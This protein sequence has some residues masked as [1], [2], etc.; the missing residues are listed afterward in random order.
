MPFI[1]PKFVRVL[2]SQIWRAGLLASSPVATNEHFLA[3]AKLII[4]LSCS[5]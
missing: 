1:T 4:S 2:E 3:N 5:V